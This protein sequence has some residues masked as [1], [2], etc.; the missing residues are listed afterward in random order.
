MNLFKPSQWPYWHHYLI[1]IQWKRWLAPA[2]LFI[3]YLASLLWLLKKGLLWLVQ[4]ML[5][6]I[7]MGLI[8]GALTWLLAKLEFRVSTRRR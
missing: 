3:P 2:I 1:R 7:V 5:A 8:L 6:P 4:I